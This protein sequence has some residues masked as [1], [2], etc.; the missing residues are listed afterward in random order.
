[1]SKVIK[2][3]FLCQLPQKHTFN[4]LTVQR[5]SV[6]KIDTIIQVVATIII[7]DNKDYLSS[8]FSVFRLV[9]LVSK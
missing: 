4:W 7:L 9:T 6:N 1:M 5:S 2:E 3:R 8:G